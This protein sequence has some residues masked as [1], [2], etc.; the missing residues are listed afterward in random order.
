MEN[1]E[2]EWSLPHNIVPASQ[3]QVDLLVH[4]SDGG[5]IGVGERLFYQ[6]I[7]RRDGQKTASEEK[8]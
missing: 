1:Q 5:R 3:Q 2:S 8:V 6:H 7:Q 4:M